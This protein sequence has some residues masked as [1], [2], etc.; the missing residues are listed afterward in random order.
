M[1]SFRLMPNQS[2]DHLVGTA[3]RCP[4]ERKTESFRSLDVEHQLNF[5]RLHH[6][7]V[8]G[9]FPLKDPRGVDANLMI[10]VRQVAAIV[11]HAAGQRKFAPAVPSGERLGILVGGGKP[12][13]GSPT[14]SRQGRAR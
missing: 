13:A 8:S 12:A 7:Q 5:H 3:E 10:G 11:H 14:K 2:L 9:F 6:P 4:R 1:R